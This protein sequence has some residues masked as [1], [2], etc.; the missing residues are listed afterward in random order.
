MKLALLQENLAKALAAVLP[1]VGKSMQPILETIK[2]V[3]DGNELRLTGTNLE[4]TITAKCGAKVEVP[5]STCVPAKLLN[6]LIAG[7]PNDRVTIELLDRTLHFRVARYETTL[8]TLDPIDF[9]ITPAIVRRA[10]MPLPVIRSA[11][12]KVAP[13]AAKDDTRPVLS[14]VRLCLNGIA[15]LESADGYRATQLEQMLEGSVDPP[16]DVVIPAKC[17]L[18][19]AKAFK[20]V[21]EDDIPIQIGTTPGI[22]SALGGTP[23]QLLFDSGDIQVITRLIEGE[24]PDVSRVFPTIY[25]CRIVVE[26]RE[27]LQAVEVA[28][29]YAER[30][31]SAG[32]IKLVAQDGE[33]LSPGKLTL[34]ANASFVGD[35]VLFLDGMIDGSGQVAVNAGFLTDALNAITTPQVAIE[36]QGPNNPLVIRPVG[37]DGYIHVI[38][39]MT[40][41]N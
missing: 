27:L 19:A 34:S 40:V 10:E 20:A 2:L 36:I 3:A 28:S 4:T 11:A 32:N 8:H 37:Q 18:A 14:G 26:Q 25:K 39:P 15:Q 13:M 7:F 23:A 41:R 9:P 5:G 6:E 21:K 30:A 33:M 17:F 35:A 29:I 31:G 1:S 24:F 38:M 22:D 16:I 12:V